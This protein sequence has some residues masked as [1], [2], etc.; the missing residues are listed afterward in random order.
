MNPLVAVCSGCRIKSGMTIYE[1]V[2][3]P[4]NPILLLY[5]LLLLKVF[6]NQLKLTQYLD[7]SD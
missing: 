6:G 2:T 4:S 1:L 7:R 5:L 3:I